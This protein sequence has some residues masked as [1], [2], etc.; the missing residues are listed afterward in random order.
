MKLLNPEVNDPYYQKMKFRP[1]FHHG[2][3]GFEKPDL[4]V[5]KFSIRTD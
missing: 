1:V 5:S 3:S 2:G 4:H